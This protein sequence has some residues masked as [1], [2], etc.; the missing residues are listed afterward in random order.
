[1]ME[2]FCVTEKDYKK[3]FSYEKDD[4]RTILTEKY[5]RTARAE[6][7]GPWLVC[8]GITIMMDEISLVTDRSQQGNFRAYFG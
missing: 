8:S 2:T 1:M 3:A 5:E 7:N 6:K 4:I